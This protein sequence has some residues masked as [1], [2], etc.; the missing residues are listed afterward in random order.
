MHIIT[1]DS[2]TQIRVSFNDEVANR[3]PI[4]GTVHLRVEDGNVVLHGKPWE[5]YLVREDKFLE[6]PSQKTRD[7]VIARAI[8]AGTEWVAMNK[9]ALLAAEVEATS[10]SKQRAEDAMLT[11]RV[12]YEQAIGEFERAKTAHANAVAALQ[13][14]VK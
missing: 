4:R 6:Q 7:V 12:A 11:A 10:L 13:G 2:A 14:G 5:V 1:A 8:A 9:K 3:V